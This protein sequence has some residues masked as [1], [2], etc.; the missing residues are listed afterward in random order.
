MN[1]ENLMAISQMSGIFK[2]VSNRPNGLVVEDLKT[3]KKKFVSAR[4]HQFTPLESVAIYTLDA[5]VELSEVF[6]SMLNKISELEP[7][8]GKIKNEDIH[9]YFSQILP[10]YDRERVYTSDIKKIIKW[11]HFLNDM[12]LLVVDDDEDHP[13]QTDS[14]ESE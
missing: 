8:A 1:L 10:T 11:F 12:E 6:T 2:L 3:G 14:D 4:K 5:T 9:A 13:N 7:P